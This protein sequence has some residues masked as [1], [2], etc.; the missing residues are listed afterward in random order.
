MPDLQKIMQLI[1][2]KRKRN[3]PWK[4]QEPVP[5]PCYTFSSDASEWEPTTNPCPSTAPP[6]T[7]FTIL[8]WNIDFM[9]P[10]PDERMSVALAH[11]Q[12]LISQQPQ[13]SIIFLNEML[14]S[15]LKLIATQPWIREGYAITDLDATHWES[16]HYGTTMLIPRSLGVERV[17]RVHYEQTA[18]ER[19][20]LFVDIPL[21]QHATRTTTNTTAGGGILR[22]CTTHLESLIADP[23]LRPAQLATAASYLRGVGRVKA[24]VVGGDFNA[25]QDFDATLHKDNG[26]RDA[27]LETGGREGADEGHTW[28]QMAPV[29]LREMFGCSRMD[30]L[31]VCGD[32]EVVGFERFGLGVEVE[33]ARIREALMK[34][35]GLEGGWVTDHVG[36]MGTFRIRGGVEGVESAAK[37]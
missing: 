3:L 27:Y 14:E 30:K 15:D 34:E 17:F 6:P 12:R 23:P 28:G 21:G 9:L 25:I 22:L 16:G 29:K 4:R 11:L 24:A 36:V 7:T 31:W 35:E 2:S 13:P 19:D 37:I 20:G 32:V 1:E 10:Y 8:S 26:L 33:D 18:M 5:Q